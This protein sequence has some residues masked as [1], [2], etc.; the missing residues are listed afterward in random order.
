MADLLLIKF[1][2]F[3]D[4][5]F[6]PWEQ[7]PVIRAELSTH[8]LKC[9]G[10]EC[11]RTSMFESGMHQMKVTVRCTAGRDV[12]ERLLAERPNWKSWKE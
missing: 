6:Y 2:T 1:S 4:E 7:H 3:S 10:C 11:V 8:L 12:C 5:M 9:N